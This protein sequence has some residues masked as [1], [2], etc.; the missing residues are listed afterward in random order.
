MISNAAAIVKGAPCNNCALSC[1]SGPRDL[2]TKEI[3]IFSIHR[4]FVGA[5]PMHAVL[6]AGIQLWAQERQLD[7]LLSPSA[8]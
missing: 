5:G 7:T 8:S 3:Q 4:G 2:A 6:L 1:T